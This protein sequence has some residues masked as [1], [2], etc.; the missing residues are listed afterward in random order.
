[1]ASP[2]ADFTLDSANIPK[3]HRPRDTRMLPERYQIVV[4]VAPQVLVRVIIVILLAFGLG[5]IV[6]HY[7]VGRLDSVLWIVLF[8]AIV[9]VLWA[10]REAPWS[11][12]CGTEALVLN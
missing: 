4:D 2:R 7:L 8:V 5:C 9:G 10:S 12:S 6:G 1:M 3:D 11:V